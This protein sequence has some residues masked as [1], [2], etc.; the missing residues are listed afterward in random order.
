[1]AAFVLVGTVFAW[2]ASRAQRVAG[3]W[4]RAAVV[5]MLVEGLFVGTVLPLAGWVLE[6]LGAFAILGANVV[7]VISMGTWIWRRRLAVKV[8]AGAGTALRT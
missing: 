2:L 6:S 5:L 1:M 7:A 8:G 3:Y 4:L